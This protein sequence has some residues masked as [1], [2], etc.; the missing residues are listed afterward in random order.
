M[1]LFITFERTDP[2]LHETHVDVVFVHNISQ[3]HTQS[4]CHVEGY[5]TY[6]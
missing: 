2:A 4:Q 5:F 3:I 1:L 6:V